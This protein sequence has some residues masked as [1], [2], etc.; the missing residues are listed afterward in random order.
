[1]HEMSIAAAIFE[2]VVTVA[3]E[4]YLTKVT[5]IRLRLGQL[6]LIVPEALHLAWQGMRDG[7]IAH[8]ATLDLVEVAARARCKACKHEYEPEWPVFLCP[9]CGQA[10]VEI[11]S[12]EELI[13]DEIT[14]DKDLPEKL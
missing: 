13:L 6:R 7:S 8:E 10:S 3:K 4:N 11:L 9:A 1:M 5:Q 12:G 14:G 2:Q